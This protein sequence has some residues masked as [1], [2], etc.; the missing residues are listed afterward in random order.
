MPPDA[1][2][3]FVEAGCAAKAKVVEPFYRMAQ[4]HELPSVSYQDNCERYSWAPPVRCPMGND[5]W[6]R[7]ALR[8]ALPDFARLY[9]QRPVRNNVF[10]MNV[11]HAFA[12]WFT[13]LAL[14]PKHIIE[15][16]VHR[17]L[18]TWLL[19]QA[20]G[21]RAN[22][23]A[24]DP[25]DAKHLRRE[26]NFLDASARTRYFIGDDFEDLARLNWTALIPQRER[27]ETLVARH[28]CLTTTCLA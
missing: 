11:N 21:E 17:G 2:A 15:S 28:G 23:Y 19:R 25:M 16:G 26:G 18:G 8:S 10:G 4:P 7:A 20:A 27:S 3:P 1:D 9:A 5:L 24:L 14:Q 6:S 12:L 13:V 22:I